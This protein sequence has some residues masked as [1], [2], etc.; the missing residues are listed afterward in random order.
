MRDHV[1]E[2]F[3]FYLDDA[4]DFAIQALAVLRAGVGIE[5]A[6]EVANI[7]V[8]F[9]TFKM[10]PDETPQ[11]YVARFAQLHYQIKELD[12]I[13]RTTGVGQRTD[14]HLSYEFAS[15]YFINGLDDRFTTLK[16]ILR[17]QHFDNIMQLYTSFRKVLRDVPLAPV[18]PPVN[19]PAED[20]PNAYY[21][22]GPPRGRGRAPQPH[23]GGPRALGPYDRNPTPPRYHSRNPSTPAPVP[24]GRAPNLSPHRNLP[25]RKTMQC[26]RC[27]GWGHAAVDCATPAYTQPPRDTRPSPTRTLDSSDPVL[28]TATS[29]DAPP[30]EDPPT[31]TADDWIDEDPS[32]DF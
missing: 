26:Y 3:K 9:Q 21:T 17:S 14:N 11:S 5:H 32:E 16:V 8:K 28:F 24:R 31:D 7:V 25:S 23:P 13:A 19:T 2:E 10:L 22:P 27:Q 20:L 12:T 30:E 1:G 6:H 29:T 4:N 15:T 18:P